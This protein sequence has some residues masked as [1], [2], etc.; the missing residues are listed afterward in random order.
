MRVCVCVLLLRV[1]GVQALVLD[2]SHWHG[3]VDRSLLL[4]IIVGVFV[5]GRKQGNDICYSYHS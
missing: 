2:L 1:L 5:A 4:F 3:H